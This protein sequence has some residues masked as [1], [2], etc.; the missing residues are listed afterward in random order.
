[1]DSP[2][3]SRRDVLKLFGAGALC[4]LCTGVLPG[5]AEAANFQ[6]A[7]SNV[8]KQ[9]KKLN[10]L[11]IN[12]GERF[13]GEFSVGSS[14]HRSALKDLNRVMRDYRTGAVKEMDRKIYD[15]LHALSSTFGDDKEIQIIC[16]YRS[17]K[18]NEMLRKRSH[19]VAERSMHLQGKAV[20]FRIA[21]VDMKHLKKAALAY[22][23]EHNT[24]GVG[25][26][27][28]FVHLD[29]GRCRCWGV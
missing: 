3:A 20:D 19:G 22:S 26:Y 18:T 2:L 27:S 24:C 28:K 6:F 25:G 11:C 4:S 8:V 10:L 15:H 14:Y 12:T 17:K 7:K 21:G 9:G 5:V 13:K 1:M 16:G 29:T 23:K